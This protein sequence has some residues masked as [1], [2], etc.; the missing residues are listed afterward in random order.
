MAIP[1]CNVNT[2]V[3]S[4]L[5]DKPAMSSSELKAKFDKEAD[6]IKKYINTIQ[7]PAIETMISNAINTSATNAQQIV[8]NTIVYDVVEEF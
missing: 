5:P 3:I 4:D 6:D 8:D 1:N 2:D 7:N